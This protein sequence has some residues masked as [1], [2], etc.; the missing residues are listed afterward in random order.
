M[1][2][3]DGHNMSE[4]HS[5]CLLLSYI[6]KGK[7]AGGGTE[8]KAG[9]I[10]LQWSFGMVLGGGGGIASLSNEQSRNIQIDKI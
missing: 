7:V 1:L 9:G 3:D 4:K 6:W 10:R 2:T 5:A 8:R